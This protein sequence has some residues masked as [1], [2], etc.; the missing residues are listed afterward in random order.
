MMIVS[1]LVLAQLI[2][3]PDKPTACEGEYSVCPSGACTITTCERCA[4][5]EYRCP[6]SEH[7]V[8]SAAELTA[9]PNLR[10]T[11]YDW[12]L[13]D[14]ERLEYLASHTSLEE[15]AAQ[16]VNKAPPI[17]RMGVPAYNWLND[18]LHGLA[19]GYGTM[20]PNGNVLGA[21]F[22]ASLVRSVGRAIATEARASHLAFT[23]SANRGVGGGPW[24][25]NGLGLTMY[26]P[27]V[28]LVRDPR[29]GRAQE[30]FGECPSLTSALVH[31]FI[32]GAQAK[33]Q[34][35]GRLLAGACCKHLAACARPPPPSAPL[36]RRLRRLHAPGS[37]HWQRAQGRG[38]SSRNPWQ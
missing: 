5:S 29:W 6:L 37:V 15:Q 25:N 23:H 30:V 8:A 32:H 3:P 33:G 22:D 27:N 35:D 1:A 12:T 11:H 21:T 10:G 31:A 4:A 28:N 36:L 38:S 2:P 17:A 7:C 13:S 16:L 19:S 24:D 9:C 14:D 18:D 20:F 34:A 26:A